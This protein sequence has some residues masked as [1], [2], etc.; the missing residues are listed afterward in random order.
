MTT[1]CVSL[2]YRRFRAP[3]EHGDTLLSPPL[4]EAAALVAENRDRQSSCDVQGRSLQQ[5]GSQARCELLTEARRYT[6]QYRDAISYAD[7]QDTA[8]LLLTGHQ[9]ELYHPGVWFKNFAMA[10]AA[11]QIGGHAI[12]LLIDNDTLRSPSIRVLEGTP[13]EPRATAMAFDRHTPE[14]PYEERQV[15]DHELFHSFATRVQSKFRSFVQA[16]LITK[17]WPLAQRAIR[18][19]RNL[20]QAVSQARHEIEGQWGLKTWE[21]PL[22]RLC[23]GESFQWFVCHLL[24]QLPRFRRIYNDSLAEYRRVHRIR[25]RTHPVPRLDSRDQWLEAPFWVWWQQR[26]LRHRMFVRQVGHQI[27]LSDGQQAFASLPLD[28]DA[29][30]APAVQVLR[31]LQQRGLRVRP[32]ALTTTM[33]ARLLASD[34]FFHGIGGAKYDQLTDAIIQRF[35]GLAP[36]AYLTLTATAKLPV[37]RPAVGESDLRRVDWMLR[38]LSFNPQRHVVLNADTQPLVEAKHR[39]INCRCATHQGVERHREI[40]RLNDALQPYVSDLRTQLL[41][42]RQKH[43]QSLRRHRLLGSRE[44]AFCLFPE[45]TLRALL[46]DF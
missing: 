34:L 41:N 24:A 12:H 8:P 42:E 16:P 43:S 17:Y 3:R 14:L 20:G 22:S 10:R 23:Q 18:R 15:L 37:P 6:E 5:L 4:D 9:P 21:L 13:D 26:P 46:L 27:E 44:Y 1:S 33:F 39:W 30:A 36:P 11:R 35:F 29:D 7:Q 25:S 19:T 45:A 2:T 31:D 28:A 32:R 38:E 40:V